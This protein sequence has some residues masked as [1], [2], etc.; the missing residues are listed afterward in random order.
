MRPRLHR[1]RIAHVTRHTDAVAQVSERGSRGARLEACLNESLSGCLGACVQK[2]KAPSGERSNQAKS[3]Q[4][5]MSAPRSPREHLLVGRGTRSVAISHNQMQSEPREHWPASN[6][7]TYVTAISR[8]QSQSVAI[9]RNQSQSD[10]IRRNQT[11]SDLQAT[12]PPRDAARNLP[13]AAPLRQS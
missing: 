8:N 10:A 4:V 13:A 12:H 2:V 3:S 11:Q 6:A 9:S 5:N 1:C 7:S